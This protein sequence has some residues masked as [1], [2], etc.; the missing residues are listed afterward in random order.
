MAW[1]LR[2]RLGRSA[3]KRRDT[4]GAWRREG[5]MATEAIEFDGG[6]YEGE[7]VD[8]K[9]Y[10][11]GVLAMPDGRRFEG[12]WQGGKRH[13]RGIY[14]WPD[15]MRSEGEFR[16]GKRHGRGIHTWPDGRRFE[17]DWRDDNRHGRGVMTWP[18]GDV[19]AGEWRDDKMAPGGA[20]DETDPAPAS[21]TVTPD[22]SSCDFPGL[23][24]SIVSR[25][26]SLVPPQSLP[27]RLNR[28]TRWANF[29]LVHCSFLII[30]HHSLLDDNRRT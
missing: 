3:R 4:A 2:V 26:R 20:L 23:I 7:V 17:G 24:F 9:P 25:P 29:P 12:G 14:T 10:G 22:Y 27:I 11:Q 15:G 28:P 18:N 5:T 13:G 8:G 21:G 1:R 30:G 19:Y 6:H 16:D